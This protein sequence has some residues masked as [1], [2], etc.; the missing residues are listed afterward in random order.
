M[1]S[2]QLKE[3]LIHTEIPPGPWHTIGTD[4]F[5]LDGAGY[6]LVA[7]YYSIKI[8]VRMRGTKRE[9]QQ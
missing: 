7:D 6:L 5:Y 3:A 8:P 4:L 1:E 9:E 2:S